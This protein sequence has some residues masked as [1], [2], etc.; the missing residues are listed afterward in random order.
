MLKSKIIYHEKK[1]RYQLT[2]LLN[3][4]I[5][6][7]FCIDFCEKDIFFL[8]KRIKHISIFYNQNINNEFILFI[9]FLYQPKLNIV[10]KNLSILNRQ[11]FEIYKLFLKYKFNFKQK[12]LNIELQDWNTF[13]SFFKKIIIENS[14]KFKSPIID[15][16]ILLFL[17][18]DKKKVF[19][20]FLLKN[21]FFY[22]ELLNQIYK[23]KINY[24]ALPI[25]N[26]LFLY[27]LKKHSFLDITC[28][29]FILIKYFRKL[30][31]NYSLNIKNKQFFYQNIYN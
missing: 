29:N 9:I 10:Y 31:Y 2:T 19:I 21:P 13:F 16:N 22:I 4:Q 25:K 20:T 17:I 23:K 7:I 26:Y 15:I 8:I 18:L 11:L 14:K 24:I 1:K 27:F 5:Q 3:Y 30:Y 6:N 12:K 28:F